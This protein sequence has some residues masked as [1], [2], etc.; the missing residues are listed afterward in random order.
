M[1][2]EKRHFPSILHWLIGIVIMMLG[3][4]LPASAPL[5]EMGVKILMI[6]VGMIYLWC[7]VSPIGGSLLA[8]FAVSLAGYQPL[9]AILGVA[10]GNETWVIMFFTIILFISSIECGMPR[11]ISHGIFRVTQGI[12][13][14]RPIVL[15][16]MSS[17]CTGVYYDGCGICYFG[18][19]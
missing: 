9:T 4:V 2:H 5:T 6:F 8:L 3:M 18:V 1:G 16:F 10:I 13:T 19:D 12:V 11:Y 15:V 17:D 14:G 7:T